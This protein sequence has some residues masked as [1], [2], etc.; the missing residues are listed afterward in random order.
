MP[1]STAFTGPEVPHIQAFGTIAEGRSVTRKPSYCEADLGW[2]GKSTYGTV[3]P[4]LTAAVS[5]VCA[6]SP[7]PDERHSAGQR[8][9]DESRWRARPTHRDGKSELPFS[10]AAVG[11]FIPFGINRLREG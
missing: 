11:D 1:S 10:R 9:K 3:S 4:D 7:P 6:A 5:G 2:L 8:A